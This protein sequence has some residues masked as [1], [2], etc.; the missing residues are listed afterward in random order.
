MDYDEFISLN[1]TETINYYDPYQLMKNNFYLFKRL[2]AN[3]TRNG[4]QEGSYVFKQTLVKILEK[5][6]Q[7]INLEMNLAEGQ[8]YS[9]LYRISRFLSPYETRAF[10]DWIEKNEIKIESPVDLTNA[11]LDFN[12]LNDNY[13][14]NGFQNSVLTFDEL[15]PVVEKGITNAS[16]VYDS[17]Q[18]IVLNNLELNIPKNSQLFFIGKDDYDKLRESNLTE[19]INQFNLSDKYR[20]HFID[21][22]ELIKYR[23]IWLKKKKKNSIKN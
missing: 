22:R 8:K 5:I 6:I 3:I 15:L 4:E 17:E 13:L 18:E 10:P 9:E 11:I 16:S 7:E 12:K 23:T 20:I 21:S 19:Q 1:E 14:G 2:Y